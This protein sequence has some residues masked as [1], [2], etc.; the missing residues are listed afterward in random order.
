MKICLKCKQLCN[1]DT[2]T[3]CPKCQGELIQY[4]QEKYEYYL[5]NQKQG[6]SKYTSKEDR[7]Y[8]DIHTIKNIL[9]LFAVLVIF[10]LIANFFIMMGQWIDTFPVTNR[11]RCGR[12]LGVAQQLIH[13]FFCTSQDSYILEQPFLDIDLVSLALFI[14]SIWLKCYKPEIIFCSEIGR[15]HV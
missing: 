10:M 2:L 5:N 9:V 3:N 8:Q 11:E 14:L 13:G 12:F 7:M 6:Y 1:D 4:S 15:A